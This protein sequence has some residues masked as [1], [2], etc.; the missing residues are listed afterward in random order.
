MI[1]GTWAKSIK[2]TRRDR[3]LTKE[4]RSDS[5][6]PDLKMGFV[7]SAIGLFGTYEAY[8]Q[9][10]VQ[11]HPILKVGCFIGAVGVALRSLIYFDM[12]ANQKMHE[13]KNNLFVTMTEKTLRNTPYRYLSTLKFLA[14]E[15]RQEH[16]AHIDELKVQRANEPENEDVINKDID[17]I[18][19]ISH[20]ADPFMNLRL[21]TIIALGC[22][23][24]ATKLLVEMEQIAHVEPKLAIASRVLGIGA[25]LIYAAGHI[26]AFTTRR[27]ALGDMNYDI[28]P[29]HKFLMEK[30]HKY[31]MATPVRYASWA[32][33]R[34]AQR[35]VRNLPLSLE[36]QAYLEESGLAHQLRVLNEAT[37]SPKR[38]RQVSYTATLS[39]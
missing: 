15:T 39:S 13:G 1:L 37:S 8:I 21:G 27:N 22:G 23:I 10:S 26:G 25:S 34:R 9:P 33:L 6:W 3:K 18:N 24:A 14:H 30:G 2:I 36:G 35:R 31:I 12:Y 20:F 5:A 16:L 11:A 29:I 38:M 19:K 4:L 28:H 7:T 17:S 32:I